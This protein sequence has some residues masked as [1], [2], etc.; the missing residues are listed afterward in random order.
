M[1]FQGGYDIKN[2]S[3]HGHF[4]CIVYIFYFIYIYVV[5]NSIQTST[6]IYLNNMKT[7]AMKSMYFYR[8]NMGK[9]E[10]TRKKNFMWINNTDK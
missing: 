5:Y 6:L 2:T 10:T 1:N 8:V 3:T 4:H 7:K 9:I